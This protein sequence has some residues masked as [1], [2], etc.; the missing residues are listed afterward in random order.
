MSPLNAPIR[1]HD[2][3]VSW[4]AEHAEHTEGISTEVNEG[5]QGVPSHVILRHW[6]FVIYRTSDF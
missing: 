5:N 6:A 2:P 1:Q 4:V 3:I